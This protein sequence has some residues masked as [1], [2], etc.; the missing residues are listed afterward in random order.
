MGETD[1]NGRLDTAHLQQACS[2]CSLRELCLPAG[3]A[4]EELHRLEDLVGT[5]GPLHRHDHLFRQNDVLKAIYAVRSGC[6]KSYRDNE[7][8]DEQVIGFHLPGDLFGLDAIY[9]GRHQCSAVALDTALVCQ[10]PYSD[11]TRL[12]AAMPSLQRQLLRIMSRD[13]G[14]SHLLSGN[15]SV[16]ER[17]AAFLLGFGD[18]M[19]GRGFSDRHFVLPMP[20]H[21]IASYLRLANETVSRVLGRFEEDGL[22]RL[23]RREVWLEDRTKL[24]AL[25]PEE[26]RL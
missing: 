12:A 20:R 25:C 24:E 13:L 14:T 3:I 11:I 15:H 8:G 18:R 16:D 22:V 2:Q 4:E 21:D 26:L 10:L 23:D 5:I 17:M 1:S 19:S 6:I 9:P 7:E